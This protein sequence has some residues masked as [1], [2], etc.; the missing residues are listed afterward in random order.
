MS[1]PKGIPCSPE[2]KAVLR[3]KGLQYQHTLDGLDSET[4][5]RAYLK[6]N[7]ERQKRKR[8]QGLYKYPD[9]WFALHK[10]D[11]Y[12]LSVGGFEFL[13]ALQGYRCAVCRRE[14]QSLKET[15]VDHDHKLRVTRGI[16]C[17]Y[18]N[19]IVLATLE[20]QNLLFTAGKYLTEAVH[21]ARKYS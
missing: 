10:Y 8:Q 3:E 17:H 5:K 11:K 2:H 6:R 4:R 9:H 19:T 20:D 14:F 18:C 16:V 13:L 21:R 15:R 7:A 1:R 12:G